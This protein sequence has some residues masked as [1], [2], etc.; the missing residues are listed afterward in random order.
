MP[1]FNNQYCASM[2]VLEAIFGNEAKVKILRLFL[3]NA[4][5][6]F[7]LSEVATRTK[8]GPGMARSELSILLKAGLLKKRL[9]TK[10]VGGKK[11]HG[12]SYAMNTKFIYIEQLK[13]L[14]ITASVAADST[15]LKRFGG[16]GKLKAL[17]ATGIF[18]QAWDSRVDLLLVGDE[19]DLKKI[20]QVIK[21]IEAEI[22]KEISYSAFETQDF[23]YRLG[24]HDRL[25]RDILDYP[26]VTLLDRL[27]IEPQ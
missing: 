10:E 18:M 2:D 7:F 6:P 9:T 15:L 23:E 8:T 26:H 17:V 16:V 11:L 13:N 19:L 24:I 3:F 12:L 27:N 4:E 5:T 20:E 25:V 1:A 21:A 14:L 22:G